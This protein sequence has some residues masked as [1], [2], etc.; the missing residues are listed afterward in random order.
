LLASVFAGAPLGAALAQVSAYPQQAMPPM[1]ATPPGMSQGTPAYPA[2]AYPSQNYPPQSYPAQSY[3][4]A[5]QSDNGTTDNGARPGHEIGVG[6]SLPRSPNT[7]PASTIAPSLPAPNAGP[8]ANVQE[9]LTAANQ[10]LVTHQTGAAEEAMEQAETRILT[11]AVP[12][13]MANQASMNPVVNQIEQARQM[14]GAHD[15]A[16]A[17][18]IINQILGSNA[19]ALA[20]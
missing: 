19:P 10:A 5:P 16:G 8:D 6:E 3:A 9:L 2:P 13:S 20:D 11:R 1:P 12:Q 14:L 15:I 18:Q 17:E 4:P 7:N